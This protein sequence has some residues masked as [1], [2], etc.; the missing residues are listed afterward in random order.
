MSALILT[1]VERA[2]MVEQTIWLC[3]GLAMAMSMLVFV[4]WWFWYPEAAGET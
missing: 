1:E 4:A 3:G 2:V